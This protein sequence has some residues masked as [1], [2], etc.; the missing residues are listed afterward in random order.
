M[1]GSIALSRA[2]RVP[3]DEFDRATSLLANAEA[4]AAR[5]I[6][7]AHAGCAEASA[8][9]EEAETELAARIAAFDA[10]CRQTGEA[11]FAAELDRATLAQRAADAVE[12]LDHAARF[13][14]EVEA[15]TPWLAELVETSLRKIIGSL[16]AAE[17]LAATIAEAVAELKAKTGLTLRV[18]AADQ[19]SIAAMVAAHPDRFAAV[20]QVSPDAGLAPGTIHLEGRGGFADIGI[21]A[22]IAA[23]LAKIEGL[24]TD[25]ARAG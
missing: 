1:D 9:A 3:K 22:Q 6:A 20:V 19:A 10:Q 12:I 13:R 18:A 17:L 11:E 5:L 23:L 24:T 2:R 25:A 7:E 8:R 4:E 21:D 16:D 14:S 15:V